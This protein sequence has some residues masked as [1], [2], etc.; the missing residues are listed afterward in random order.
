MP[1]WYNYKPSQ[2][3]EW[4][5]L[6]S[7][8]VPW[9]ADTHVWLE[10]LLDVF[11]WWK[12]H[13]YMTLSITFSSLT[14]SILVIILQTPF[15]KLIKNLHQLHADKNYFPLK[16]NVLLDPKWIKQKHDPQDVQRRKTQHKFVYLIV[17]KYSR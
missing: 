11:L 1:I 8:D 7:F 16:K 14:A 9:H 5:L 4:L 3:L 6:I 15:R 12:P 17:N 2:Y 10:I 13:A